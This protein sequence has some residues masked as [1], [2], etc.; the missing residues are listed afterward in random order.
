[1]AA[2]RGFNLAKITKINLEFSCF[3]NSVKSARCERITSPFI[4]NL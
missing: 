4:D 3:D 2:I 1:M